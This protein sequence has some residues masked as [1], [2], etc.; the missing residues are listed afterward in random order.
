MAACRHAVDQGE[1]LGDSELV[2]AARN[3]LNRIESNTTE[4]DAVTSAP[5]PRLC[6]VSGE[7]IDSGNAFAGSGTDAKAT[8]MVN[9]LL[10]PEGSLIRRRAEAVLDAEWHN[11]AAAYQVATAVP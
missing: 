4:P 7:R 11:P 10:R 6:P 1:A 5:W 8:A 3:A 9:G 2:R